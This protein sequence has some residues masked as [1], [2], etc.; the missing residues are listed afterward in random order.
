MAGQQ[1]NLTDVGLDDGYATTKVALADGRLVAIPSR[2][3][4][5]RANVV[6]VECRPQRVRFI[7]NA[8]GL[9]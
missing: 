4:F 2:A 8:E 9:G 5:G 6:T 3:R 7:E 1:M